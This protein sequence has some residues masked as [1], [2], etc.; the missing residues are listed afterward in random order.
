MS[1]GVFGFSFE[2]SIELFI[3][4]PWDEK[5]EFIADFLL[6]F[7]SDVHVYSSIATWKFVP[8]KPNEDTLA[9]LMPFF[10]YWI[11]SVIT[12]TTLKSMFGFGILKF[13]E[14]GR[15]FSFKAIAVLIKLTAPAA[16]FECP[17]CDFTEVI[18]S[19]LPER[20]GPKNSLRT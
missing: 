17:I 7:V 13:A 20:C 18:L 6:T 4:S 10:V 19:F 8:P 9:L 12:S 15:I 3:F 16:A 5:L 1:Y 14:G 11:G 2:Y